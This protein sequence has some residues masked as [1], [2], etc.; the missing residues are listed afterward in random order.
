MTSTPLKTAALWLTLAAALSAGPAQAQTVTGPA[1]GTPLR[2][3][4]V[5]QGTRTLHA[6]FAWADQNKNGQLTRDEARKHLP[7]TY[8]AF[9]DIDAA[10]RGWISYEQFADF[11]D[12]RVSQSADEALRIGQ[13]H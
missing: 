13:W 7:I 9:A 8:A 2:A 11:T 5:P 4:E 3:A 1:V 10:H 6:M 12:R